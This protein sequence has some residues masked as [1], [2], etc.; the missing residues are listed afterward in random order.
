[1]A[2]D[3]Q[4][5]TED[6]KEVENASKS[7]L[8]R[9]T[10]ALGRNGD[11][12]TSAKIINELQRLTRDPN[13]TA[14]QISSVITQDPSLGIRVL[15]MVNSS[16]YRRAKPITD[17]SQAIMQMGMTQLTEMCA[18]LVLLQRLIPEARKGG[19]FA[20][21]LRKSISTSIIASSVTT[22][23]HEHLK[24]QGK[25]INLKEI[26][27]GALSGTM[28]EL[29]TLLLAYY[30]PQIYT[31][32]I[33]RSEEKEQGIDESI[34]Q[35]TGFSPARM[36]AHIIKT[37]NLPPSYSEIIEG[38]ITLREAQ[39]KG[40]ELVPPE[41]D[42]QAR[43]LAC[44]G[45]ISESLNASPNE[46]NIIGNIDHIES[47]LNI[48]S[49]VI[50]GS[51]EDLPER[52]DDHSRILELSLPPFPLEPR[53]L[54]AVTRGESIDSVD[55]QIPD[56][57]E[58]NAQFRDYLEEIKQA[59]ENKEPP[60]SIVTSTMEILANCFPFDRVVLLMA[61]PDKESLYGKMS[62]G[63]IAG[64]EVHSYSKT[65][66]KNASPSDPI[67]TAFISGR[68][69]YEGNAL[70]SGAVYFAAVPAGC[71]SRTVGVIYADKKKGN[72][73]LP[74]TTE[75]KRAVAL[76]AELLDKSLQDTSLKL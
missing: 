25:N 43:V 36:S 65:L 21:A 24:G 60:A 62:L 52:I 10:Q 50:L 74:L 29:G 64:F 33:R 49:D 38:A 23:M 2:V 15:G 35:L 14:T 76:I 48:P 71:G 1:M 11:F 4:L 72:L 42:F 34:Q 46:D 8:E 27:S 18:G 51:L 58:Q 70:L 54:M 7:F 19:P 22:R 73:A 6:S 61:R 17:I 20:A 63:D 68:P 53:A 75:Q 16:F 32:A 66:S 30:F 67:N 5:H 57:G 28:C 12:P 31:N 26:E 37:L 56:L 44:A 3:T 40:G 45:L 47:I 13:T 41:L 9:L 69:V 59:I 39:E 55:G